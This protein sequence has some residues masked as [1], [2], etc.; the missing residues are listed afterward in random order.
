MVCIQYMMSPET[1][2]YNQKSVK[3]NNNK[4]DFLQGTEEK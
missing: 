4:Y 1:M 2:Q 3:S